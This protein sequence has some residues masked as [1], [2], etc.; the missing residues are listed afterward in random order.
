MVLILS[1]CGVLGEFAIDDGAEVCADQYSKCVVLARL[2]HCG[3]NRDLMHKSCARACGVCD[4]HIPPNV[5]FMPP[6]RT[7]SLVLRSVLESETYL[8]NHLLVPGTYSLMP[9]MHFGRPVY[10]SNFK[11]PFRDGSRPLYLFYAA[12]KHLE[13][14]IGYFPHG[15]GAPSPGWSPSV[16]G[17]WWVG[18][19]V[20][21]LADHSLLRSSDSATWPWETIQWESHSPSSRGGFMAGGLWSWRAVEGLSCVPGATSSSHPLYDMMHDMMTWLCEFTVLFVVAYLAVS[22]LLWEVVGIDILGRDQKP[23]GRVS[24]AIACRVKRAEDYIFGLAD[25]L[26]DSA[27][28]T[29]RARASAPCSATTASP[30]PPTHITTITGLVASSATTSTATSSKI[31]AVASSAS[32]SSATASSSLAFASSAI[33]FSSAVAAAASDQNLNEDEEERE[34]MPQCV[35]CA[36]SDERL[37]KCRG[38]LQRIYCSPECQVAHWEVHKPECKRVKAERRAARERAEAEAATGTDDT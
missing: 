1:L 21:D 14:F 23:S 37:K 6:P 4:S 11:V 29:T 18:S 24:K 12:T 36:A 7:W 20:S 2:G 28:A 5:T 32:V 38:C 34:A 26:F 30:A 33:A 8:N 10:R 15:A 3:K 9:E 17:K 19:N 31:L 13:D 35:V 16:D 25:E 27:L 22:E